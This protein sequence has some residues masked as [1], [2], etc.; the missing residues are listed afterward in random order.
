[1]QNHASVISLIS[2]IFSSLQMKILFVCQQ[3]QPNRKL[4]CML[5]PDELFSL[6]GSGI[7]SDES[8]RIL[9][10]S[11]EPKSNVI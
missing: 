6:V 9:L 3:Q 7:W 11:Q 1:M 4:M 5:I 8:W 2:L 10:A